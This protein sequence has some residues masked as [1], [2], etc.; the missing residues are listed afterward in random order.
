MGGD[1][2][3]ELVP[4][5][6]S[7]V[8]DRQER[9][10][11][12]A[13]ARNTISTQKEKAL[14]DT[15]GRSR[16]RCSTSTIDGDRRWRG[17]IAVWQ[18]DA[19]HRLDIRFLWA[20]R[21]F[22]V[23]LGTSPK[24]SGDT[25][26]VGDAKSTRIAFSDTDGRRLVAVGHAIDRFFDRCEDTL[27]HT[28]HSLRCCLHSYYPARSSKS[29]LELPSRVSTRA[30]YR[31]L[32]KRMIFFCIRVYQLEELIRRTILCLPSPDNTRLAT[33]RLWSEFTD[34]AEFSPNVPSDV[35]RRELPVFG[36]RRR[37][38]RCIRISCLKDKKRR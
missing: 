15:Q 20:N 31:S 2:S 8:L 30:R 36:R 10:K 11:R 12:Y 14:A 5:W 21:S 9:T 17:C 16:A 4:E 19:S 35:R 13:F 28:G 7:R 3:T 38:P 34:T 1:R 33:Q 24:Q 23:M 25:F 6:K 29:P 26:D 27:R 32:W 37:Y 18:L 22:L